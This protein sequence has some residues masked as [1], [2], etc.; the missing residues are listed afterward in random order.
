MKTFKISCRKVKICI[1]PRGGN[2]QFSARDET[3]VYLKKISPRG[4]FR[5][6]CVYHACGLACSGLR[7]SGF[8][9]FVSISVLLGL[10]FMQVSLGFWPSCCAL[11]VGPLD[12]GCVWLWGVAAFW[13]FPD[14]GG[15][16][17]CPQSRARSACAS[18]SEVY[19]TGKLQ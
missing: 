15:C 18:P 19:V 1:S 12:R 2:F 14:W 6:A 17:L 9:G 3:Y 4:E 8:R 11:G 16:G 5:L 7:F 13:P 10:R